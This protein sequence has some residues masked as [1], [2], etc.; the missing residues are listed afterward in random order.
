MLPGAAQG[1]GFA[2]STPPPPPLG[3]S[4]SS[5]G[6]RALCSGSEGSILALNTVVPLR[7]V[8]LT[9]ALLATLCD[10]HTW[11]S[12]WLAPGRVGAGHFLPRGWGQ[13][14]ALWTHRIRNHSILRSSNHELIVLSDSANNNTGL[15]CRTEPGD[16]MAVGQRHYHE[17]NE[18]KQSSVLH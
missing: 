6:Y 13:P 8:P 18:R 10:L 5:L 7:P 16:P 14:L 1:V 3:R 2:P 9:R 15:Q 17:R 11:Y 4:G 12:P